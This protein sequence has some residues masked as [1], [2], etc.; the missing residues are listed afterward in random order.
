MYKRQ[1]EARLLDLEG[2]REAAALALDGQL[3]AYLVAEGGEDETRQ[4]ALRE[5][6]RTALR[7]SLIH[8]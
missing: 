8:I 4:P 1:V 7:L 3:V 6:I 2:I 5:R